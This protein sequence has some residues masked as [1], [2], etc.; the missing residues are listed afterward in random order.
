MVFAVSYITNQRA[1]SSSPE[2]HSVHFAAWM[3]ESE[4]REYWFCVASSLRFA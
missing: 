3:L 1:D 2:G 4:L